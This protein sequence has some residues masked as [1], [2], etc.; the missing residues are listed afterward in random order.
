MPTSIWNALTARLSRRNGDRKASTPINNTDKKSATV[1]DSLNR[2]E[3]DTVVE[4]FGAARQLVALFDSIRSRGIASDADEVLENFKKAEFKFV[5]LGLRTVFPP[6]FRT[7]ASCEPA[8]LERNGFLERVDGKESIL[9][10]APAMA[11]HLNK[12]RMQYHP[13]E[14]DSHL[15]NRPGFL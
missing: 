11:R 14:L 3:Q 8:T 10:Y 15:E 7:I 1:W 5:W 6:A 4:Y 9:R 12:M 13:R 2:A